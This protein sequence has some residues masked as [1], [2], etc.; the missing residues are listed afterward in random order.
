MPNIPNKWKNKSHVPN[1]QPDFLS[2]TM[3]I[4]RWNPTYPSKISIY[5]IFLLD[6][7]T[8]IFQEVTPMTSPIFMVKKVFTVIREWDD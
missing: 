7:T 3:M 4:Y 5:G 2:G 1:H 8:T 6:Q